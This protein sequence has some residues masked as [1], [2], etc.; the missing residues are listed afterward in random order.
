[1]R[2]LIVEDTEDSRVLLEE[3]FHSVGY[4][5]NSASNGLE[6]LKNLAND[7]PDLIVSDILMP[8]MD[9]FEL[10]RQVKS[11]QELASIPFVFYTAT[12]TEEADKQL[13]LSLGAQYFIVKPET[14][15]KLLEIINKVAAGAS[16]K[17]NG[18]NN[19]NYEDAHTKVLT[20]KLDKKIHELELERELLNR[21]EQYL[22]FVTDSV[23]MLISH[24]DNDARYKY[25]NKAYE[26]WHELD[27]NDVIGHK[28]KD[29]VGDD[30]WENIRLYIQQALQ[31]DTVE[32]EAEITYK[33]GET[34]TI[35]AR[36]L[37]NIAASGAQDGF[38]ALISDVTEQRRLQREQTDLRQQLLQSQKMDAIGHMVG[39]IAHDFNNILSS[40]MGFTELANEML[41]DTT[42]KVP[43]Y[44]QEVIASGDR[45]KQLIEQMLI[46]SRG[47]SQKRDLVL[48]NTSIPDTIS[49]IRKLL[50]STIQMV[51]DIDDDEY[52]IE[53]NIVQL[54]QLIMNLCINARDA[55]SGKGSITIRLDKKTANNELCNSCCKRFAGQ[56]IVIN[57]KDTGSGIS[58]ENLG[59][60][61]NPF[62]T[63]KKIGE[64]TGMGLSVVHGIVHENGGHIQI[65][66]TEGE[67][68]EFI[69]LLPQLAAGMTAY[70]TSQTSSDDFKFK[71][72]SLK[73]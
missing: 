5:V 29:V 35:W 70:D 69:I 54:Q 6:A 39:G 34:K 68:T 52:Y 49:M 32:Y 41:E 40:M 57:I 12:Y 13:A 22:R 66:S 9:G 27:R 60:I 26:D 36:Y 51:F 59:N 20:A 19:E 65:E 17:P 37:P 21:K 4:S 24:V 55:M 33:T 7:K 58:R 61:F 72:N 42:S 31:G 46:Y 15:D 18:Q 56:F 45:A 62:Y 28:V 44:L 71:T 38:I 10:C 64:G 2:I 73:P 30:V 47:G 53:T 14:P 3:Y 16:M 48:L 1:M 8:K 67:G 63:T 23:P 43:E 11:D 25:V 50:P